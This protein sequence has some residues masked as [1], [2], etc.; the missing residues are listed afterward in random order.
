MLGNNI[1]SQDKNG[2][3]LLHKFILSKNLKLTKFMILNGANINI[4]NNNNQTQSNLIKK[5]FSNDTN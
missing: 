3:T 4:K 1:N 2:N 5:Y